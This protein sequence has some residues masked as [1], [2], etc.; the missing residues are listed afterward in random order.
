MDSGESAAEEEP[1][2]PDYDESERAE[3]DQNKH[4]APEI[5]DI[6]SDSGEFREQFEVI[7]GNKKVVFKQHI[8]P[9][10]NVRS[11]C[12]RTRTRETPMRPKTRERCFAVLLVP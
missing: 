3:A 7:E 11:S 1:W 4:D 5:R 12:I 9:T 8:R 6:I 2:T 10:G